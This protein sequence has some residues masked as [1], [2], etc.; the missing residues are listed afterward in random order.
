[1]PIIRSELHLTKQQIGNSAI[2]AVA[3]TVLVRILMG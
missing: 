3:I 2:A 1:M